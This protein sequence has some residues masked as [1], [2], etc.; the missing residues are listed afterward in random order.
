M[1]RLSLILGLM[2]AF[3][4]GYGQEEALR[5]GNYYYKLSMYDL[6]EQQYRAVLSADPDNASAQYNLASALYKQKKY[7]EATELFNQ[8]GE[9]STVRQ[10]KSVAYYNEGAVYSRQKE[11]EKSIEAYKNSLRIDPNDQQARENLQKALQ[12]L[13]QQQQDKQNQQKQQSPSK[14]S[15]K[16][17]EQKLQDLQDKEKDLQEKLQKNGQ[18]GNSMPKDW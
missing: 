8:L 13:R 17:A 4:W 14:M 10:I 18:K 16:Q 1:K 5:K 12:E 11:L 9:K 7:A 3:F 6:A 2:I 15:Q